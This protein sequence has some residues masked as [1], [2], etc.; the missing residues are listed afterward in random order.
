MITGL[1]E[2]ESD[3]VKLHVFRIPVALPII[4]Q[5]DAAYIRQDQPEGMAWFLINYWLQYEEANL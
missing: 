5:H 2:R 1:N 3:G 4:S